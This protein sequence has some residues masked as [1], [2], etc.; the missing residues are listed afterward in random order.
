MRY[1]S[2]IAIDTAL[3]A[4]IGSSATDIQVGSIV[5]YPVEFPFTIVIDPDTALEELCEVTNYSGT[6]FTVTRAFDSTTAVQHGIGATVKH[7]ACAADFTEF[8]DFMADGVMDGG[9]VI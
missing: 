5:G 1:Y 3:T 7:V 6:T 9:E 8:Q 4:E 2:S